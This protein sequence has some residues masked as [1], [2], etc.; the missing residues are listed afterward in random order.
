MQLGKTVNC[1]EI[2]QEL[3]LIDGVKKIRTVYVP[4]KEG[5]AD[6]YDYSNATIVDGLSFA[7]WSA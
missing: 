7:T 3:Y 2:C 5:T 1:N 6:V 4:K